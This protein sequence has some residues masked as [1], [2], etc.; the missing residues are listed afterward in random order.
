MKVVI[1]LNNIL[2]KLALRIYYIDF[3][4][5]TKFY[6]ANTSHYSRKQKIN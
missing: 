1:K 2:Y 6:Q 4:N 3:D 5:K